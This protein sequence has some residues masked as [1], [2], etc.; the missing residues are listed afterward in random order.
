MFLVGNLEISHFLMNP[1]S[2]HCWPGHD[3]ARISL[4]AISLYSTLLNSIVD[5]SVLECF[6]VILKS[7]V[8]HW[9]DDHV[10]PCYLQA[11]WNIVLGLVLPRH[12]TVST[13]R[14]NKHLKM[15]IVLWISPDW[16]IFNN[17]QLYFRWSISTSIYDACFNSFQWQKKGI[18]HRAS[19]SFSW[20]RRKTLK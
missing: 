10:P 14:Y 16:K 2:Q 4:L 19:S 20:D 6:F 3:N 5:C 7:C 9:S 11:S 1:I 12:R 17:V 18:P 15:I 8:L 13:L